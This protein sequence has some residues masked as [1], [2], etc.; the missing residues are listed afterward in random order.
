MTTKKIGI[1]VVAYNAAT[2]LAA[3]LDRIPE[4]FRDSITSV[5]VGDDHS[6][7]QTHLVAVG[8][9][10]LEPDLP[11]QI[12][13]HESNLGYGGNQKWGYRTAIDQGLDIIVLLHGDGQYAPELLPQMVA[14]LINDEA[15]AV[16]GS[17][18][19]LD[20]GARR[21][22]MPMYKFV[23]N[24]ILT[25]VENA[26]AG[27]EL[28][29]WHSGYRAYSVAALAQLPFERNSD[30]FD[31][32]TQIILQL[33]ESG[34]RIAEIPIPTYY[35]EEIS[36]VNGLKYAKDITSEVVRYRAHKMGFG[37][38]ELAFSSNAY[39]QK[40][41]DD[42]SHHILK[43][44]LGT[45]TAARVLDLGC[46]DGRFAEDLQAMGHHV[47]G[48]D[49]QAHDGVTDRVE[50]FVQADLDQG[51]PSDLDGPFEIVLA[52]DVL[53]HVRRPDQLLQQIHKVLA[54]GG[55]VLVS[56]PNFGHWYPR[57]RV[58]LGRFDYDRRGILDSD[59][60][61]FFTKKSFER[62]AL[63]S[64]FTILRREATGLPLEVA[65][66]GGHGQEL[67]GKGFSR[68]VNQIDRAAVAAR[69]QLFGYQFLFELRANSSSDHSKVT[70]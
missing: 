24:R 3:V 11:L 66:R 53:E 9:Q 18:M 35:G 54:P 19:M 5:I 13:R 29:E 8:Y 23:G 55:S 4:D 69:P 68:L 1:L 58:A 45:R 56:V 34:Q 67:Q 62:L 32:D 27:V 40:Q 59:H 39:E 65:E 36:H 50:H 25:T 46:S 49:L 44:W 43:G 30:G 21:G 6:Q 60:V 38:G 70:E 52:A 63:A 61:R 64:G 42:S 2:T 28:T 10:Q 15:E 31:F 41:G 51:L 14:P 48:V 22:G 37:T 16:F 47:T 20:G 12:T 33:I 17:R 57:L 7:D 26:V